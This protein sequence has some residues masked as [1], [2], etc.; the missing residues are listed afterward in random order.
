L[1]HLT[2]VE[3][4]QNLFGSSI[5][6]LNMY[7]KHLKGSE[8]SPFTHGEM[9]QKFNPTVRHVVNVT[10]NPLAFMEDSA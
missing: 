1:V 4:F 8:R 2:A 3:E 10:E 6:G 7:P 9:V 5:I